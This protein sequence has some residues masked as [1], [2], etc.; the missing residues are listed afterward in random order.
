MLL[1]ENLKS[2]AQK[3]P[4]KVAVVYQ[5]ER[6]T[7][8]EI[9]KL[10]DYLAHFLLEK[11]IKKGDRVALLLENSVD[12][13]ISF[14][15]ILKAAAVVVPLNTQLVNRELAYL[16]KDCAPRFVITDSAHQP[17]L[18]GLIDPAFILSTTGDWALETGHWKLGTG[19]W[20]RGLET[21]ALGHL[22]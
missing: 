17:V 21:G 18:K 11:G 22:T 9:D 1:H 8:L 20:H 12:Y 6:V 10:S 14:F 16:L 15:G 5:K 2:S 13:V 7:Y 3:Y 4:S 19:D